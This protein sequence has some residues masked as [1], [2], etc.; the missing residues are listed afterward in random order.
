[1]TRLDS[2][3]MSSDEDMGPSAEN[4]SGAHIFQ[5]RTPVWRAGFISSVMAVI[6][7][8]YAN[9]VKPC[10]PVG[11]PTRIRLGTINERSASMSP[12]HGLPENYY[13][14]TWL[15]SQL[16]VRELLEIDPKCFDYGNIPESVIQ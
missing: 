15:S 5:V 9:I 12:A 7:V 11:C 1:M 3:G 14:A 4:T 16:E 13:D 2:G 10:L 6:D 8:L